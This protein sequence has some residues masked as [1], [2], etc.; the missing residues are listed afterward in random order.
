MFGTDFR[1]S[2]LDQTGRLEQF[3]RVYV[4]KRLVSETDMEK[5]VLSDG[6]LVQMFPPVAGGY[7][8]EPIQLRKAETRRVWNVTI[9]RG[10]LPEHFRVS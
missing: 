2:L 10:K 7:D 6:D 8:K 4:N 5:T 9:Q 1:E 3:Y